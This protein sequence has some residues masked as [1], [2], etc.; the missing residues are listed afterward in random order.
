MSYE[1]LIYSGS[2]N[3]QTSK[4]FKELL[5][6]CMSLDTKSIFT[7]YTSCCDDNKD[8]FI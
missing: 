7:G 4:E 2:E 6:S 3:L 1:I 5:F 8:D